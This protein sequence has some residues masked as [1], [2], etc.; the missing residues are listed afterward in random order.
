MLYAVPVLV[1][2]VVGTRPERF[3]M[4]SDSPVDT[5]PKTLPMSTG[6]CSYLTHPNQA[7]A[8]AVPREDTGVP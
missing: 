3:K 5:H 8:R 2:V 6:E 1:V 7:R 4:I